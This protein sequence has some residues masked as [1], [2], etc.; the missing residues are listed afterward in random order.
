MEAEPAKLRNQGDAALFYGSTTLATDFGPKPW[1]VRL[2]SL[3]LFFIPKANPDNEALYPLVKKWY[4]EIDEDGRAVRE[5]G[6]SADNIVLFTAPDDRNVGF[7]TDSDMRFSTE[8]LSAITSAEFKKMWMVKGA[9]NL[10]SL[11]QD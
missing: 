7:W 4:V 5:I 1:Q 11:L 3:L 2:L 8:N 10:K 9:R 6:V